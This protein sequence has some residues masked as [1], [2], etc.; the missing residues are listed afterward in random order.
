MALQANRLPKREQ[1]VLRVLIVEDDPLWQTAAR[2]LLQNTLAIPFQLQGVST[3]EAA[4]LLLSQWQPHWV[5]LD[6]ELASVEQ[7]EQLLAW[8]DAQPP[9]TL[10][11]L[12]W[13]WI[14]NEPMPTQVP[15]AIKLLEC[16]KSQWE[17]TLYPYLREWALAS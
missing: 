9:K 16:P 8:A 11:V 3:V 5:L 15:K 10:R 17:K 4:Q 2:E 14:S 7:G 13:F 12:E 1:D 6:Q